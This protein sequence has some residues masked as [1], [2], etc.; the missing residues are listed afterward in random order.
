VIVSYPE[1]ISAIDV[2]L[3]HVV[4][5]LWEEGIESVA[6]ADTTALIVG[7]LL[8]LLVMAMISIEDIGELS[9]LVFSMDNFDHGLLKLCVGELALQL[10]DFLAGLV[11][12][13]VKEF[14]LKASFPL[15]SISIG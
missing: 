13:R 15:T 12:E 9:S 10:L 5:P 14:L 3:H 8:V 4:L 7:C 2:P 11:V 6:L 1:V